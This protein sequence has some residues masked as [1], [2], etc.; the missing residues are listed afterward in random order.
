TA[1]TDQPVQ[2]RRQAAHRLLTKHVLRAAQPTETSSSASC[3]HPDTGRTP[4]AATDT[5]RQRT[6]N[7]PRSP[8]S[9]PAAPTPPNDPTPPAD[10][11]PA[12]A[13]TSG[14][15]HRRPTRRGKWPPPR[16]Q[17]SPP[18]PRRP[19]TPGPTPPRAA[20]RPTTHTPANPPGWRD[21]PEP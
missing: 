4:R 6:A 5:A 12:T 2:R 1:V 9:E 14:K 11:H 20:T 13:T 10:R 15:T 19:H 7:T 21:D 17:S 16:C 18:S 3:P 8:A